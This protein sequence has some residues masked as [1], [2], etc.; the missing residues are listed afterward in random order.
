MRTRLFVVHARRVRGFDTKDNVLFVQHLVMLETV[1]E[2]GR[3][4]FRVAGEEYGSARHPLRRFLFQYA[5]EI[6]ERGSSRRG[7][8]KTRDLLPRRHV[9]ITSIPIP[10]IANGTQPPSTTLSR[11]AIRKVRSMN[12]NGSIK[13]GG[14]D[15]RPAPHPPD[16]DEGH[17]AGDHHRASDGNAVGRGHSESTSGT[18]LQATARRPEENITAACKSGRLDA[19][20]VAD[21]RARQQ[22]ELDRLTG[23]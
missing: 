22:A 11:F 16:H 4:A 12:R 14:G 5:D 6:V 9:Y 2:R 3:R 10:P 13:R 7:F 17:H 18:P 19:P 20:R 1:Q 15:W 23:Q 8:S 21:L